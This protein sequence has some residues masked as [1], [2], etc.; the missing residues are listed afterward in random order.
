MT[1]YIRLLGC[2]LYRQPI[3]W[4][5]GRANNGHAFWDLR[6]YFQ[7]SNFFMLVSGR[8][9]LTMK[10]RLPY[11]E[12]QKT[13]Q[14]LNECVQAAFSQTLRGK[15]WKCC[16]AMISDSCDIWEKKVLLG[17]KYGAT[18]YLCVQCLGVIDNIAALKTRGTWRNSRNRWT[19]QII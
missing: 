6:Y 7:V 2:S 12:I 13:I 18:T 8:D 4:A 1:I 19:N 14:P 16:P 9:A 17:L 11:D 15:T 3:Q 10:Q 5:Q